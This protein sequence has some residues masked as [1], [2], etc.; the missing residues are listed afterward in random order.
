MQTAEPF[1]HIVTDLT[2]PGCIVKKTRRP[3]KSAPVQNQLPCREAIAP[4][5]AGL[6][7]IA[8]LPAPWVLRAVVFG[9]ER[10]GFGRD[11]RASTT[12]SPS[13]VNGLRA[14]TVQ[15]SAPPRRDHQPPYAPDRSPSTPPPISRSGQDVDLTLKPHAHQALTNDRSVNDECLPG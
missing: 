3:S 13:N 6:A 10:H 11:R 9:Q 14:Q 4:D 12:K 1:L 8:A 15:G 2:E 7:G 5:R